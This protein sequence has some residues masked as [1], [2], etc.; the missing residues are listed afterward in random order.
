MSSTKPLVAI[1]GATGGQGGSVVT[2]FLEAGYS[3]RAI[4]RN[5]SSPKSLALEE[6]GVEVVAADL[7]KIDTLVAAFSGA[8]HIFGVTD[9]FEPFVS[10]GPKAAVEI[11]TAQGI[12]LARAASLTPTLQ[13]YIWS[14]LPNST[15]ISSGKFT[16]PHFEGKNQ[17]D[18]FIKTSPE[19]L[20][21]TTFLWV[22]WFASNATF[23]PFKPTFHSTSGKYLMFQPT[24][25]STPILSIGDHTKNVG[26]F[27]LAI[28]RKPELTL[29][30]KFVLAASDKT[31]TGGALEAWG[32]VT[33]KETEYV[34]VGLEQYDRLF[35]DWGLEFGVMME[36]W[37]VLG[38][39]SWT[40]EEV[41]RGEQL[42]VTRLGG[43]ED[44]LRAWGVDALLAD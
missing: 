27:V 4:T 1:T 38:D 37:G 32:R 43:L 41:I 17:V 16:V 2:S 8:T 20:A 28:A 33:G 30:G 29:P 24:G 36:F 6:R 10:S 31:T 35:P 11:E 19:L 12:N 39:E 40:G 3:V 44:G 42:G 21:K 7:N 14:T 26:P 23:P 34:E 22:T 15:K 18:A 25:P 5:T 13:H 9:F